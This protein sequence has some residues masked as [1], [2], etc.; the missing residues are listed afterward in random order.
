MVRLRR[1]GRAVFS[2]TECWDGCLRYPVL[3]SLDVILA[4]IVELGSM[5]EMETIR[6]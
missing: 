4:W 5:T 3:L 2:H 6:L 1:R